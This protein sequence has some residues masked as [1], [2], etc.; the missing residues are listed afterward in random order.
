MK[1]AGKF[2]VPDIETQQVSQLEQGGWQ[3][4]HL[5]A[6]LEHVKDWNRAIDGGAHVGSWT[7]AMAQRFRTVMAFEPAPDTFECLSKNVYEM[8]GNAS[9][10][11]RNEALGEVTGVAGM[12]EDEKYHGGNTGGRYLKPGHSVNIRT[13]DSLVLGSLGF[14]KLDVEGYEL[15]ALRG[16]EKTIRRCRPVVL[17]EV[18]H[19]M[20]ARYGLRM[21]DAPDYLKSL[22]MVGLAHTGSDF[23]FGW[24]K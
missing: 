24:P 11:L 20:A 6:A 8:G 18:K 10:S 15:F 7:L 16:G 12:G 19:R 1:R 23:V 14:L 21:T 3:L 13:L 4:E 22:G 5:D 17:I 2:W 9:V